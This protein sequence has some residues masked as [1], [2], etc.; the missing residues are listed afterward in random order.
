MNYAIPSRC[1]GRCVCSPRSHRC[2]AAPGHPGGCTFIEACK[3]QA[4]RY[5]PTEIRRRQLADLVRKSQK[6]IYVRRIAREHPE[7]GSATTIWRDVLA[8]VNTGQLRVVHADIP[9]DGRLGGIPTA[10]LEAVG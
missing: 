1:R 7:F 2:I 4:S 5:D 8:L 9:I 3:I 10:V 6:P